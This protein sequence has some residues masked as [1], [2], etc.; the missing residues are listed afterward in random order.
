MQALGGAA[1]YYCGEGVVS[2]A[3]QGISAE[4]DVA[5]VACRSSAVGSFGSVGSYGGVIRIIRS[6]DFVSASLL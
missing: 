3:C 1:L 4:G 6:V 2:D 5:V